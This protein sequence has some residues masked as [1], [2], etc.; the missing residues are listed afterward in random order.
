MNTILIVEDERILREAYQNILTQEGFTVL[1]AA[2]GLQAL[3]RLEAV[4]PDLILLD[5]LMPNMDGFT[6]LQQAD[7]AH[8]FPKMK[9]LAFSN[10]SDHQRLQRMLKMGV[11]RHVLKSSLS[12]RQLVAAIRAL[13]DR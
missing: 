9:V 6:F 11:S 2:D 4:H 8:R 1:Q 5:L 13:L 7:L 3:D 10:M 12:P